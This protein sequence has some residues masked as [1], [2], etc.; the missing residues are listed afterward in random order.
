MHGNHCTVLRVV[1]LVHVLSPTRDIDNVVHA[2]HYV[3]LCIPDSVSYCTGILRNVL[4]FNFQHIFIELR[5]PEPH[6]MG[7]QPRY[8]LRRQMYYA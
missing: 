1:V 2:F 8:I 3:K 7:T 4:R 5:L 6:V